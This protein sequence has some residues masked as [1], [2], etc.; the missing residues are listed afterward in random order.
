MSLLKK[1]LAY[2]GALLLASN[3]GYAAI[4]KKAN[5]EEEKLQN[6]IF[7]RYLDLSV[8]GGIVLKK[9]VH[10]LDLTKPGS[11]INI[12][13]M[14]ELYAEKASMD[15]EIVD[16][17]TGLKNIISQLKKDLKPRDTQSQKERQALIKHYE[18]LLNNT[19]EEKLVSDEPSK[20]NLEGYVKQ[21]YISGKGVEPG[22]YVLKGISKESTAY[23]K[24]KAPETH[25]S[26]S[27]PILVNIIT[28][29]EKPVKDKKDIGEGVFGLDLGI[30]VDDVTESG[31][32]SSPKQKPPVKVPEKVASIVGEVTYTK[33]E[34]EKKPKKSHSTRIGIDGL[35]RKDD[36]LMGGKI[37][38][39]HG[40][41]GIYGSYSERNNE[42]VKEIIAPLSNGRQGVGTN[43]RV[44]INAV[45]LGLELY[46][47][48]NFFVGGGVEFERSTNSVKETILDSQ[49]K[50]IKSYINSKSR[51]RTYGNIYCGLDI[52]V[53]RATIGNN[54]NG[55]H[56]GIGFNIKIP[57]KEPGKTKK[58]KRR[59]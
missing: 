7:T 10:D 19:S 18:S 15:Y 33:K 49:G 25:Y 50:E 58:S 36:G 48:K 38:L 14:F 30:P 12:E 5:Q 2:G 22:L 42:L 16:G 13:E 59:K 17:K 31:K 8:A 39:G 57:N 32:K 46:L 47:H 27:V 45:G 24:D 26:N 11:R 44:G 56:Y 40:S 34:K 41:L 43:N 53:L 51:K 54:K 9:Y 21:G 4:Q 23:V 52:G 29:P 35:F 55:V 3:I 6:T 28:A 1:G 20:K 37:V